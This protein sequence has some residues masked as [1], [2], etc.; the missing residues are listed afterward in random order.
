MDIIDCKLLEFTE[1]DGLFQ[2][3]DAKTKCGVYLRSWLSNIKEIGRK[4]WPVAVRIEVTDL[5]KLLHDGL[6]KGEV[7]AQ[8]VEQ[9]NVIK[10]PKR[11]RRRKNPTYGNLEVYYKKV[12]SWMR[13]SAEGNRKEEPRVRLVEDDGGKYLAAVLVTDQIKNKLFWGSGIKR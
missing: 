10:Q 6:T 5:D 8:C 4:K 3:A 11:G 9:L 1:Y 7:L 12:P 13:D 2:V